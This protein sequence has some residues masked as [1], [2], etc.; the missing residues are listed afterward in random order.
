MTEPPEG[1]R[2]RR[3]PPFRAKDCRPIDKGIA[4]EAR[5]LW[6]NGVETLES[7]EGGKEHPFQELTVRFF[8]GQAEGFRALGVALLHG[9]KVSELRRYWSVENGKPKGRY[10]R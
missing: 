3:R 4:R 9:L 6:E 5:V 10:G 8:G 7:C 1:L 2:K